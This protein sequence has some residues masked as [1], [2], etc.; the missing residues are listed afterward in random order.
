MRRT[1]AVGALGFSLLV[2]VAGQAGQ[3]QRPPTSETVFKN[4]QVLKGIPADEFMDAMGM[5]SASLGYDCV[6]CHS[7]D[8]YKSRDSVCHHHSRDPE[9][10]RHDRDD[11]RH[12]QEL[13][14]R[15]A[16]GQLLHLPSPARTGPSSSPTWRC[17]TASSSS[18]PTRFESFLIGQPGGRSNCREVSASTRRTPA[19]REHHE[20]RCERFYEGLNTGAGSQFPLE[21]YVKAPNQRRQIIRGPE[22]DSLKVYD[23]GTAWVAERWRPLPLM[24]LSGGNLDGARIEALM[25]F[26][27]GLR[28]AFFPTGRAA[29]RVIDAGVV[30]ILAGQQSRLASDEFLFRRRPVC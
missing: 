24:A 6:S 2:T 17:N 4:V 5:F 29:T 27:V 11:E 7:P 1:G 14:R 20:F 25:W 3:D 22:G 19:A 10:A 16:A 21:I 18:I 13:F 12:Q 23:G 8:I 26:P 9:S 15:A 30:Q 28:Q